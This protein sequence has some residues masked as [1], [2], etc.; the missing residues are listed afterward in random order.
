MVGGVFYTSCAASRNTP[1]EQAAQKVGIEVAGT[2]IYANEIFDTVAGQ[3]SYQSQYMPG[4]VSPDGELAIYQRVVEDAIDSASKGALV[5]S[6]G[7]PLTDD[8]L[9]K[10]FTDSMD[11]Q[12]DVAR[13]QLIAQG[14]L[15]PDA[16]D[17][18]FAL[19]FKNGPGGGKT[20]E[21][22]KKEAL[23]Q[24]K[25]AL[26]DKEKHEAVVMSLALVLLQNQAASKVAL[27]D[28]DL[29]R[30]F[31]QYVVK[32]IIAKD[33]VPGKGK[34]EER[35]AKAEAALKSGSTFEKAIDEFSDDLPTG[36]K[37]LSEATSTINGTTLLTDPT[38]KP[39]LT[40]KEGEVSPIVKLPDGQ[41]IYKVI[42]IKHDL[43]KD[44]KTRSGFYKRQV[45]H[46]LTQKDV[47]AMVEKFKNSPGNVKFVSP[48]LKLVYDYQQ[49][50]AGTSTSGKSLNEQMEAINAEAKKVIEQGGM[51]ARPATLAR[52]AALNSLWKSPG[53]DKDKYRPQMIDALKSVLERAEIFSVRMNL[54]DLY[55][56]GK[57]YDDAVAELVSAV[58]NNR[59]DTSGVIN[60]KQI[61]DALKR[62]VDAKQITPDQQKKVEEAQ[63][64]WKQQADE[65][66]KE[67]DEVAKERKAAED[68]AKAAEDKAKKD[69]AQKGP[70]PPSAPG[71]TSGT[72][73]I[74][75]PPASTAGTPPAPKADPTKG[76]TKK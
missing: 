47:D 76:P 71:A 24:L 69:A 34:P 9:I 33:L 26:A 25:K 74:V 44:F 43:P 42:S 30:S 5:R 3:K 68:A 55:V 48:G 12:V 6:S 66:Q 10:A 13:S 70:V 23:D 16:S 8:V 46:D 18:E 54:V 28:A 29:E 21:D 14:K 11:T 65:F 50:Q 57:Q 62:L 75:P 27:S 61:T 22:T 60:D 73:P 52:Y 20:V 35:I 49:A 37:K 31:D 63:K 40:L 72:L 56:D 45:L 2:P 36:T 32:R 58:Q 39:L 64:A 1:Q 51:D 67:K 4:G 38:F 15:K 7:M 53:V 17:A 59:E 41:A 19:A